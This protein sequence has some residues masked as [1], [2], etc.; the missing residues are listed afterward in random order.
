MVPGKWSLKK[1]LKQREIIEMWW[2][3]EMQDPKMERKIDIERTIRTL[4]NA[5]EVRA[6]RKC[7]WFVQ[8]VKIYL[9]SW[10]NLYMLRRNRMIDD[11]KWKKMGIWKKMVWFVSIL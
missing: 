9:R 2:I 8:R 7:L 11:P 6:R 5:S 4:W 10:S 1:W 3:E